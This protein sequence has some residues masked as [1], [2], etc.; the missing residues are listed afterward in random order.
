MR[1][2]CLKK[3]KKNVEEIGS[4]KEWKQKVYMDGMEF[5]AEIVQIKK[6]EK[7][8]FRTIGDTILEHNSGRS[9]GHGK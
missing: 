4:G 5:G 2:A 8:C 6:K 3:R 1:K 7:K 9:G